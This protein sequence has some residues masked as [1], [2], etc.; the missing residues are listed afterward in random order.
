MYNIV[1]STIVVP[2]GADC[3]CLL[4]LPVSRT[5]GRTGGRSSLRVHTSNCCNKSNLD[6]E[7]AIELLDRNGAVSL[8]VGD[9]EVDGQ[10][11]ETNIV[12]FTRAVFI[13]KNIRQTDEVN[14]TRGVVY[15]PH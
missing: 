10:A 13:L 15:R 3:C 11:L 14:R 1:T 8:V 4:S 5:R 9:V 2:S 12:V 6:D 7:E